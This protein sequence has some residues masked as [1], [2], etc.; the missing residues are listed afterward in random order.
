MYISDENKTQ[1]SSFDKASGTRLETKRR[2]VDV[3]IEGVSVSNDNVEIHILDYDAFIHFSS[4]FTSDISKLLFER[5]SSIFYD[6]IKKLRNL[7]ITCHC[8]A[9]LLRETAL[10]DMIQASI[11]A[12]SILETHF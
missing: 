4:I 6:L 10:K 8:V 12:G 1:L 3:F 9:Y 11:F 7:T 5:S 2:I